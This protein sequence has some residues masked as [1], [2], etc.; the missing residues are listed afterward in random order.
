MRILL[1]GSSLYIYQIGEDI[2]W[3]THL[4]QIYQNNIS[5]DIKNLPL[6]LNILDENI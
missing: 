6:Q 3:G 2:F 5:N 1:L 4:F